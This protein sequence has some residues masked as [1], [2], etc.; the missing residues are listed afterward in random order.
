[1]E[2][3]PQFE[4]WFE[5]LFPA[6]TVGLFDPVDNDVDRCYVVLT[7]NP[8]DFRARAVLLWHH[9]VTWKGYW[10]EASF[11]EHLCWFI[12]HCP[13]PFLVRVCT[14]ACSTAPEPIF[15]LLDKHWQNAILREPSNSLMLSHAAQL[16]ARRDKKKYESLLAQSSSGSLTGLLA[17]SSLA[18]EYLMQGRYQ[19][20]VHLLTLT[21]ECCSQ[22]KGVVESLVLRFKCLVALAVGDTNEAR[23]VVKTAI[24][25]QSCSHGD[26][27]HFFRHC[28][29]IVELKEGNCDAA[30]QHL[31]SSADVPS[32]PVISSF[33]PSMALPRLLLQN[34]DLPPVVRY[35]E[36]TKKWKP[37]EIS[38][39]LSE[40]AAGRTP[41]LHMPGDIISGVVRVL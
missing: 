7:S 27:L 14:T 23:N 9:F 41:D 25:R 39:W 28:L 12:D 8:D 24:H 20:C 32:A 19:D 2:M 36:L 34:G 15:R 13:D 30:V 38:R 3:N 5:R 37:V 40:I 10:E 6:Y 17:W 1:M 26:D 22:R 31:F 21:P 18:Q 4:K 16:F 35:L 11:I 33:G 29:G